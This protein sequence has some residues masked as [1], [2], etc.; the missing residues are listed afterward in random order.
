MGLSID[1]IRLLALTARKADLEYN[2]SINAMEKMALAREQ[3]ELTREYSSR[4][5]AKNIAYY[6]NGKYNQID[7][8]YLMGYTCNTLNVMYNNSS[9]LKSDNSMILTDAS[10]LVVLSSSYVSTMTKVLGSSCINSKGRG[11]TF[12]SDKIPELIAEISSVSGMNTFTPEEVR[13]VMNG[14]NVNES[15]YSSKVL[16]TLTLNQTG[17]TT[18]SNTDT[19]TAMCQKLIDFYQPIFQAAAA[20][21]WTTEYNN[22]MEH[23]SNYVNDALVSGTFQLAQ[24]DDLGAYDPETSLSYF[25]MSG[26]VCDKADASVREEITA[27]YNAEK[28]KINEKEN[29]IDLEQQDLSTELEATKTEM[30]S[31]KSMLEDDMKPFEWCT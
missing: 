27:W 19:L 22:D 12:S 18:T 10:G 9:I 17:S 13:N 31:L 8:G 30:E 29:W 7:Y 26:L 5:Q 6:A 21:G 14:G 2:I 15:S 16:Q 3:A 11:G 1:N 28:E 25:V 20:N 4:M 23:N 24:V